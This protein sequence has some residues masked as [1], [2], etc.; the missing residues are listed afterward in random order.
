[1]TRISESADRTV[2]EIAQLLRQRYNLAG[3]QHLSE[4]EKTALDSRIM[5]MELDFLLSALA[6]FFRR[7]LLTTR[8]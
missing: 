8:S 2:C 7:S 4:E 6:I 5:G 3:D 1:M